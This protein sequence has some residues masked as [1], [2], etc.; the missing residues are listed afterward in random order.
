MVKDN[1]DV[2]NVLLVGLRLKGCVEEEGDIPLSPSSTSVARRF[3]QLSLN[4]QTQTVCS[5]LKFHVLL[6]ST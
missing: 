2:L 6:V 5:G 1:W 3:G 4:M